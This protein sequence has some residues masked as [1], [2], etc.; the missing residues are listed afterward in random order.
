M[1]AQLVGHRGGAGQ[2]VDRAAPAGDGQGQ[3]RLPPAVAARRAARGRW[4]VITRAQ[5]ARWSRSSPGGQLPC[6]P[7]RGGGGCGAGRRAAPAP[8]EPAGRRALLRRGPGA[9]PAP[10]GR[11]AAVPRA[12]IRPTCWSRWTARTDP[13]EAS[14]P[15]PSKRRPQPVRD[16]VMASDES[17][18]SGSG[19]LR[20]RHT[21][22]VNA[23][24]IPHKLDVAVPVARL[25]AYIHQVQ[26]AILACRP[27][28]I[29]L[30]VRARRGREPARERDGPAARG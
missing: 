23:A 30:P 28:R 18:A 15:Q 22:S 8:A 5:A 16:V 27:G 12:R 9:R 11:R 1:R 2:R 3:H 29:G 21:E 10:R 13:T 25:A 26:E 7:G 4:R 17:G 19:S 20:E 14:W 24:G 6:C